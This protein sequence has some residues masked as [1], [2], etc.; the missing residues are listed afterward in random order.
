MTS[1]KGQSLVETALILPVLLLLLFGIADFGRVFNAYLTLDL[2]GREGARTATIGATD[3][4]IE[5]KIM[6]SISGLDGDKLQIEILPAGKENRSSGSDVTI[7]LSYPIDFLTP[8]I[9]QIMDDFALDDT[10][11]MRVE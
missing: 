5:S 6:R 7:T 3:T 9:G 4:E 1:Q 2:A 10:T 8:V 11:V